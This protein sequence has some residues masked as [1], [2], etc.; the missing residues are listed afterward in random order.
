MKVNIVH[1]PQFYAAAFY[2][3]KRPNT[4]QHAHWHL[5]WSH[6]EAMVGRTAYLFQLPFKWLVASKSDDLS[7]LSS[8]QWY[9]YVSM[10]R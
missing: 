4:A 6:L 5:D 7:D 8:E 1:S 3:V 10:V 9:Q 2:I